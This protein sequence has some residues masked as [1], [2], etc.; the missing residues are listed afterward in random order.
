MTRYDLH[1][2]LWPTAF[3]DV[4]RSRTTAPALAGT[5]LTT[6]EGTFAVDLGR[7][8]P[9][10]RIAALDRDGID[11]AVLSLQPCLGTELLPPSEQDELELA[12]IDGARELVR[13]AGGRFRALAPWRV[14]DGFAGT[15][16]GASALLEPEPHADLLAAVDAAPDA[17]LFVHPEAEGPPPPGRPDWWGW[18]AGYAGQLQ[19]AYLAWLAGGRERLPRAPVVFAI[20]AGGGP[21]LLER[22]SHRGIEVR[23]ALDP[24]VYFD[25]ATHGRRAIELC[26]ETF[27]AG[28]LV[29]GSDTPVV[30]AR[31][32]LQAVRGFGDA[33]A[34][35]LQIET[36]G[37]LI[38]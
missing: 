10:T 15:S 33:V 12:W 3:L 26:I 2:H 4:L 28:Q 19:R 20:L 13:D 7:H 17:L 38:R 6:P 11:V 37:A 22:L 23:S 27:G 35:L 14:V 18:T 5:A 36:P 34:H 29:Y 24:N 30:E 25:T 8:D 31:L 32:T 9:E 16:V 1:Q 21:F